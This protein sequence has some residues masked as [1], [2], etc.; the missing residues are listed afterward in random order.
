MP[1]TTT[2]FNLGKRNLIEREWLFSIG[3]TITSPWTIQGSIPVEYQSFDR[4][5]DCIID[6]RYILYAKKY[7][8]N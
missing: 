3:W 4:Y 1:K 7:V 8:N 2:S 5:S 6:K